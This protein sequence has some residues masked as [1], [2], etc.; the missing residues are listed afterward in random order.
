MRF[1]VSKNVGLNLAF[2]YVMNFTDLIDN[3]NEESVGVRQGNAGNDNHLYGSLGLSV[4]L[5]STKRGKVLE[6]KPLELIDDDN[7]KGTAEESITAEN[8][9]ESQ[10]NKEGENTEYEEAFTSENSE[11]KET[12]RSS[13]ESFE[14]N[15]VSLSSKGKKDTTGLLNIAPTQGDENIE[16]KENQTSVLPDLRDLTNQPLKESTGFMWADLN[17]DNWISPD[18]V[19]HFIDLLFEGE[20]VRSVQDIQNLIDYYF[21][22]E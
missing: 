19:L 7:T 13:S 14:R 15:A 20:P 10:L 8:D 4:F 9:N 6:S 3:V 12:T 18:E 2:A 5:G 11:E 1:Q 17:K 21:D 16:S 22:Q